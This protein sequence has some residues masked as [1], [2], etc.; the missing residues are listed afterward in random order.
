MQQNAIL[1][2]GPT[3][4]GKT[5]LAL[6]LANKYPIEIISVDS[7]LIYREMNIGSAKPNKEQLKRVPHH[8]IDT[9]SPL[10]TYSV[11]EFIDDAV[12]LIT[13]INNRG[14]IPLLVGGTIMYYN[15]LLNGISELPPADP[16]VREYIEIEAAEFGWQALHAKL[17]EVDP[18][19]GA[20]IKPA[21][22]QRLSRA[23]EVYYLTG[24]TITELQQLSK[25]HRAKDIIFLPLAII[26][27]ERHILHERIS[28]RF[29][30]MLN[31]GLIKEVEDLRK[32][33]PELTSDHTSMRSVG[34]YQVWQYLD[35]HITLDELCEQGIIATRQLAKRQITWLR[36]MDVINLDIDANLNFEKL[37]VNLRDMVQS[38]GLF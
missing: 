38:S 13:D 36:S 11:A 16:E 20:K 22:K 23:L 12:K 8:L 5:D 10:E 17:S 18:R 28:T 7:V 37:L 33:Y 27:E 9:L 3:A 29:K 32:L 24:K 1:L 26:P 31:N 15:A 25:I 30:D 4:T 6:K 35:K 14:K 19:S 2:M 34:Y 21:D